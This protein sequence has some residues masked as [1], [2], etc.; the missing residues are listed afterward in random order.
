MAKF[1][2]SG[3]DWLCVAKLYN[4]ILGYTSS[5]N[6]GKFN[7]KLAQYQQRDELSL[8][9]SRNGTIEQQLRWLFQRHGGRGV[10]PGSVSLDQ[11]Q[12]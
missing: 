2:R 1:C 7:G 3:W 6:D 9:L 10:R 12:P 4:I 8:M 5:G 11:R